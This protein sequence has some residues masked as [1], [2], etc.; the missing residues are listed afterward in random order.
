MNDLDIYAVKTSS[1]G[2]L[3]NTL[4]ENTRQKKDTRAVV[5]NS[6]HGDL[7]WTNIDKT[8]NIEY[9][10][11]NIFSSQCNAYLWK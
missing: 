8:V 6:L 3:R 4:Q 1:L 2:N 5:V 9:D 7:L 11:F 10:D